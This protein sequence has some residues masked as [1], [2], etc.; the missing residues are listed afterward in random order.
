MKVNT[1]G[2]KSKIKD[3]VDDL[4]TNPKKAA[5]ILVIIIV[6]VFFIN[7][8]RNF[9]AN[10]LAERDGQDDGTGTVVV[11]NPTETPTP[12]SVDLYDSTIINRQTELVQKYGD[13][14]E[15]YLWDM[16]GTLLSL[17][18]PD[19]TAEEALYAYL[20]GIRTLDFSSAQRFSRGSF[21]V[22]RYEQFF[23]ANTA[24]DDSYQDN[25]LRNMYTLVLMSI[26]PKG[27]TN[28]AVFTENKQV[29]TIELE[30]IDL[31]SK[32]FW[33]ADKYDLYETLYIYSQD[34]SDYTKMEEYVY[35]YVLDYYKSDRAT[36][37]N[38]TVNVT[39]EKYAGLRTG[40]LITVDKDIDNYC[41]YTDGNLVS[42]YIINSFNQDGRE[43]IRENRKGNTQ[44]P[45]TNN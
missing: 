42:R 39:V 43:Y 38:V 18:D 7:G 37:R 36:H 23:D 26:Q 6:F 13:L 1:D 14:P 4:R 11:N 12:N 28:T 17:G 24:R 16:D 31:S 9:R 41:Y 15:G 8:F 30:M 45:D 44:D 10:Q 27:V 40:W 22:N 20:N 32:D 3:I 35:N 19:A 21:V 2:I 34:E 25:F 29:F 33:E 5:L